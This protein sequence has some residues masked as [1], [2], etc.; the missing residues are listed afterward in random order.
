MLATDYKSHNRLETT[1]HG[2]MHTTFL[3]HVN[4]IL[5]Y[6]LMEIMIPFLYGTLQKLKIFE[7]MYVL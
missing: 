2:I 4:L 6:S 7:P 3:I 5:F 1:L